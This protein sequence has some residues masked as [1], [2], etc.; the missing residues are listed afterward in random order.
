[1][2]ILA[3]AFLCAFGLGALA[4]ACSSS[5][6]EAPAAT[7]DG[8]ACAENDATIDTGGPAIEVDA[9]PL[10]F[11]GGGGDGGTTG[12]GFDAGT[13]VTGS[14][15]GTFC[16]S[17]SQTEAEDNSVL[18]GANNVNNRSGSFCGTID[19]AEDIDFLRLQLPAN[20]Q[21][22]YMSL[23]ASRT[24]L[25]VQLTVD[26]TEEA[27]PPAAPGGVTF[28]P[29]KNYV[30]RLRAAPEAIAPIDYRLELTIQ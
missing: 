11:A 29:G 19:N 15:A 2:R 21:S 28:A 7:C 4:F 22:L 1:M 27:F 14:D 13:P 18:D 25:R 10:S 5:D 12:G 16:L 23:V 6:D 3:P 26:G 9:G 17:T 20:A 24:G 30:L 8:G